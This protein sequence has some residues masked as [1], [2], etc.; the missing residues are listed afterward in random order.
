MLYYL[1]SK[2]RDAAK[3][4]TMPVSVPHTKGHLVQN[5]NNVNVRHSGIGNT[6]LII[7]GSTKVVS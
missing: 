5:V 7:T 3:D 6:V 4:S 1:V 2:A